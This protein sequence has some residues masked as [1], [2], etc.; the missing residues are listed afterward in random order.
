MS[1]ERSLGMDWVRFLKA[2]AA[3]AA[4]PSVDTRTQRPGGSRR[5]ARGSKLQA[6]MARGGNRAHS[7]VQAYLGARSSPSAAWLGFSVALRGAQDGLQSH[8]R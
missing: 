5:G 1:E 8:G 3:A 4:A 2:G 6:Q 7:L